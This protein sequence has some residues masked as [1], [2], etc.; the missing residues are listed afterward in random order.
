M[1]SMA[2]Q[3]LRLFRE[4]YG[5]HPNIVSISSSEEVEEIQRR[6]MSRYS[7]LLELTPG[8]DGMGAKRVNYETFMFALEM[9]CKVA[10]TNTRVAPQLV[11][12]AYGGVQVEWHSM[13]GD[14]EVEIER[15]LHFV[16]LFQNEER[17][18]C[19]DFEGSN[20]FSEV[21]KYLRTL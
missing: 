16:A 10:W 14:L 7:G 9:V 17:G 1:P 11:P 2:F 4:P 20:D 18:T 3:R 19:E 12:L 15:P 13:K 21:M 6:V 5:G 8:W